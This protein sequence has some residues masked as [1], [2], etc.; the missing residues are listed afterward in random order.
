M[1]STVKMPKGPTQGKMIF[2]DCQPSNYWLLSTSQENF[3]HLDGIGFDICGSPYR[4]QDKALHHWKAVLKNLGGPRP[5][6]EVI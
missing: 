5:P 6:Q 3:L 4:D 1:I 2:L